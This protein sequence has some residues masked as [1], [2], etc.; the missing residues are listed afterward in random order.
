MLKAA[1]IGGDGGRGFRKQQVF[2]LGAE[3]AKIAGSQQG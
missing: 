1:R 2:V 3:D